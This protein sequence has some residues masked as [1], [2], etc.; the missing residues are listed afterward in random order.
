MEEWERI[1]SQPSQ[2]IPMTPEDKLP[3]EFKKRLQEW[4][5]IKKMSIK[6]P[7][8]STSTKKKLGDWPKWKSVSGARCEHT[9]LDDKPLSEDFLKKL[10]TWKQ[11]KS[12]HISGDEGQS[13]N[14]P[15]G[16]KTPSPKTFKKEP[17]S[18]QNKKLKEQ[19][20]K[21]LQWFD[22]ELTKIEE[23]RQRLERERQKFLEKEQRL[24]KLRKPTTRGNKKELLVQTPTG[25]FRFEGISKEF[26]QKLYEW[27][28]T[29]GIAPEASTFAL[30]NSCYTPKVQY[31][32]KKSNYVYFSC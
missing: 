11:I 23:E 3:P 4:Q 8:Y 24:A 21:E 9:A 19:T 27:E 12:G 15:I 1:K 28:R 20:V 7:S 32:S 2:S 22:K 31:D 25:F 5:K 14:I 6:E 29:Q 17:S 16:N 26:T 30:L 10:E 18:R 13:K